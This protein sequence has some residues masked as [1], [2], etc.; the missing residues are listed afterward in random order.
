LEII[1]ASVNGRRIE[2]RLNLRNAGSLRLQYH[3]VR[4]TATLTL[5]QRTASVTGTLRSPSKGLAPK[6]PVPLAHL[7]KRA[8]TAV[9]FAEN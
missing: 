6:V 7:T 4:M 3:P 9:P 2:E 5:R 8:T 1:P